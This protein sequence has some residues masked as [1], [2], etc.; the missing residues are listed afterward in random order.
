MRG[1]ESSFFLDRLSGLLLPSLAGVYLAIVPCMPTRLPQAP[2]SYWRRRGL[3]FRLGG[4]G[5]FLLAAAPSVEGGGVG[6]LGGSF[7]LGT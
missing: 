6:G 2:A 3:G 7:A 4:G 5:G 1:G